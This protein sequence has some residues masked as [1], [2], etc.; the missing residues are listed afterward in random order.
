LSGAAYKAVRRA[1]TRASS[2]AGRNVVGLPKESVTSTYTTRPTM[3][4][5]SWLRR[6]AIGAVAISCACVQAQ[7]IPGTYY[8]VGANPVAVAV[9]PVTNKVYVANADDDTV[10]VIDLASHHD[11][12]IAVGDYPRWIAINV[13]SNT[14]YVSNL[15]GA[16]TTIIDGAT[17]TVIATTPSVGAGPT[18]IDPWFDR[19]YVASHG[20]AGQV[21]V[22]EGE[23]YQVTAATGSHQ[24]VALA[25]NPPSRWLYVAHQAGD[26][27]AVDMTTPQANP[28]LDDIDVP[29]TPVAVAI[30]PATNRIYELSD[31]VANPIS[32]ID[33]N[34]NTF[35]SLTPPGALGSARAIAVNPVTNKAYA[36][37]SSAVVAIDGATNAM[38]VIPAGSST[39]GPVAIAIDVRRN[40][41]YVAN[42]N[43]TLLVI[44][45]ANNTTQVVPVVAGAKGIAFN[46][47]TR[48]VYVVGTTAVTEVAGSS[49][50]GSVYDTHMDVTVTPLPND[51]SGSSG[52]ITLSA[53]SSWAP[54]PL[55]T[56]RSV[57]FE[58]DQG[59]FRAA[60]PGEPGTWAATYSGL[61]PGIHHL[62]A[63]AT[64]GLEAPS[65]NTDLA[66][67]PILGNFAFYDFVVP[68]PNSKDLEAT[69]S[70]NMASGF[71][72]KDVVYTVTVT[73]HGPGTATGVT[74]TDDPRP[75]GEVTF[76]WA[77]PGC[78][79]NT[80]EITCNIGTLAEGASAQV[81]IVLRRAAAGTIINNIFVKGAEPDP[82]SSN[83]FGN[84]QTPIAASPAGVP[85]VRYRLYSPVTQEH[86]FTTDLNEYNTLGTEQ[87]TWQQ[88]GESGK[89]LDNP[90]SFNGVTAV[91]YYRL[92][93]TATR[94]HHWTTDPNEYYTLI[95]YPNWNAEGVDGYL[96]PTFT[97]GATQL[98]RLVYPDGRGLHHWTIDAH[99]YSVLTS[100][101]GWIGEGG[102]GFVIQ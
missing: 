33:G 24:P 92:Y 45:G 100:D 26:V 27:V 1:P 86:L 8:T 55:D 46:P 77:S 91:P 69:Q 54:A 32:V 98:Y 58:I 76:V 96:L 99:E 95:Q 66:N 19:A 31:N 75:S 34:D 80:A 83:D 22:I 90:G 37:F 94:W 47:L 52:A 2:K 61:A 65:I 85:V 10:S 35:T 93:N 44:N 7:A 89:V 18:A 15:V 81:K 23:E 97:T 3:R 64:N 70:S 56:V 13:E 36:A 73:N 30:N 53:S 20:D 4:L 60:I 28:P 14:I 6:A 42:D 72:G 57:Y 74:L 88:E 79:K 49:G 21:N 50:S 39:G 40:V 11:K 41:I 9:N 38:T 51:V 48:Q 71:T 62:F 82:V 59:G 12:T 5:L 67:V 17:D 101:Y 84:L 29:D 78:T 25:F 43:G 87:G 16:N 63:F 68:Q 102:A